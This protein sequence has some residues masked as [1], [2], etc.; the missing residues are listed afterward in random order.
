LLRHRLDMMMPSFSASCHINMLCKV[1]SRRKT[2]CG[3]PL[4]VS[5][6]WGKGSVAIQTAS[7]LPINRPVIKHV[8]CIYAP[9]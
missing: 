1:V 7:G 6:V 4:Y 8:I 5:A 2:P 3:A 9:T